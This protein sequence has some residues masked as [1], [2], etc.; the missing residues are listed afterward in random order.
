MQ[1]YFE[2][3]QRKQ[4][5]WIDSQIYF[6]SVGQA[7][8]ARQE[9]KGAATDQAHTVSSQALLKEFNKTVLSSDE[10]LIQNK[11]R[12][13]LLGTELEKIAEQAEI[14]ISVQPDA[15]EL[16]RNLIS[17]HQREQQKL[18]LVEDQAAL[19]K[20]IAQMTNAKAPPSG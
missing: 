4:Q 10:D 18:R 1:K 16:L 7:L 14:V 8:K 12:L 20:L 17:V 15:E 9:Q 5:M 13:L 11:I 3:Q 2:G 19:A 6:R